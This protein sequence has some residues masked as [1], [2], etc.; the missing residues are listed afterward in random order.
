MQRFTL[1]HDG[2]KQGWQ[3]AYLAFHVAAQLGAPLLGLI[4]D[5]GSD[6]DALKK[7]AEQVEVGAHAAG[8]AIGTQ[9]IPE[10]SVDA[11]DKYLGEGNGFFVP[12]RIIPDEETARRFLDVMPCPLWL[13]S[14][15]PGINGMAVFVSVPGEQDAL[16]NYASTLSHRL[17]QTLTGLVLKGDLTQISQTEIDF[18]WL[19]LS[20]SK[21]STISAALDRAN[22]NLLV[23]SVSQ[24]SLSMK[25]SFSCIFYPMNA[26]T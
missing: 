8:V 10:F 20:D 17:K 18:S 2:S 13:V 1:I 23:L 22:A 7:R 4:V 9:L 11:V 5:A 3:T 15:G 21:R 26:N 24:F 25:T 19:I 6:M 16:I 12:R 14:K